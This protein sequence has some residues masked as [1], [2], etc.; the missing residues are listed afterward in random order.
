MKNTQP[1]RDSFT[2]PSTQIPEEEPLE[3]ITSEKDLNTDLEPLATEGVNVFGL[4]ALTANYDSSLQE[5]QQNIRSAL[6]RQ[7]LQSVNIDLIQSI[8]FG[9]FSIPFVNKE[10]T[11]FS[12]GIK[13]SLSRTNYFSS[14]ENDNELVLQEVTDI[15]STGSSAVQSVSV[16]GSLW[17]LDRI[18]QRILPLTGSYEYDTYGS[19]VTAYVMDTGINLSH[20]EFSGRLAAG[21]DGI[22]DGNGTNDCSGHGTHVSGTL[23]GSTYGVAKSVTLVPVRVLNC[24]GQEGSSSLLIRG[25]SWVADHHPQGQPAVLNMSLVMYASDAIDNAVRQVIADGVVVVAASGNSGTINGAG[26][27]CLWSPARVPEVITVNASTIADDDASFSNYGPCSDLYAPGQNIFSAS[28][29]S[30]TATRTGSGTSMAT[31]HVAGVAARVLSVNPSMS[32]AQVHQFIVSS[33]S[34]IDF[35]LS[36]LGDPNR[37]LFADPVSSNANYV[38]NLYRDFFG[39]IAAENEVSFWAGE[40]NAGRVSRERLTKILATSD[41]WI[42]SVIRS[43]Y[44]DTLGREPEPSGYAFWINQARAGKPIADIGSFFYGSDEYFNSIG[45]A[46]YRIWVEDLYQKQ[47]LRAGDPGGIDFWVQQLNSGMSRT[48]VAHWFY[49]SPEKR[50]L[51]VDTLYAKLLNRTSDPGGRAYWS[52]RLYFEGDL[53]LASML[54]Q[55]DEYFSRRYQ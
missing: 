39:R 17:G 14:L 21:F 49:Q 55:S 40:L 23:G 43:F 53:S 35:G 7:Q 52:E 15:V 46:N 26:N 29:G 24:S 10:S 2:T 54:A 34:V 28:I 37:L 48:A 13:S 50:G 11:S 47:M 16:G 41:E 9:Y 1:L 45:Q 38:R 4:I 18:D 51:R 33:A 19:G 32:P 25:L 8:G 44:I 42:S 36:H 3:E 27:A 12:E 30:S 31:P 5:V 6:S 22:N 20:T